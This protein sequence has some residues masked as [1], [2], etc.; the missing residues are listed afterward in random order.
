MLFR[1]ARASDLDEVCALLATAR[2]GPGH[3]RALLLADPGFDPGQLRLAWTGGRIVAC[4]K[5]YP[6]LLRIGAATVA[7]GGIAHLHTDPSF[8]RQGLAS[9][10]LVE[11]LTAMDQAGLTLA[12][13]TAPPRALYTRLGWHTLT[14]TTLHL[15]PDA[16]NCTPGV[17]EGAAG[18]EAPV[19]LPSTTDAAGADTIPLMTDAG[20]SAPTMP[21][22]FCVR[23]IEERDLGGLL[24]LHQTANRGRTGS[25]PH[26]ADS[27]TD[28]LA[29]LYLRGMILLV[30]VEDSGAVVGFI[31]AQPLGKQ[32][33]V[34]ELLVA[35]QTSETWRALLCGVAAV[36]PD[37]VIMRCGLPADYR[38][39]VREALGRQVHV[40]ERRDLL[41]R[42]VDPIRLLRDLTAM[43]EAR[44][45]HAGLLAD[46]TVRFGPLPGGAALRLHGASVSITRPGPADRY[47]V[48]ASAFLALLF[49]VEHAHHDLDALALP[50]EVRN[51][52]ARLFPLQDWVFWRSE[53][54]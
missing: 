15:P 34:I 19:T 37:A 11:C 5:I 23:S 42:A 47:V 14:E 39:V 38:R 26:D 48:P 8:E 46:L 25:V 12:I 50:G 31:A 29:V 10:L 36:A 32:V 7:V 28:H 1:P 33:E 4:A 40:R 41:V 45:L 3:V 35:S 2:E 44:V 43:L 13:I 27:L 9:T 17:V 20:T 21:G 18:A 52:L 51:A 6:R 22:T 54:F 16:L 30:A 53:A 49:G 24:A